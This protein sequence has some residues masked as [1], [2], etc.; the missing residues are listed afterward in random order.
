MRSQQGREA[1]WRPAAR[2]HAISADRAAPH[3]SRL[4][5]LRDLVLLF[6]WLV[7][8]GRFFASVSRIS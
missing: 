2:N 7:M 8:V 3:L 4:D 6:A 5:F 1:S